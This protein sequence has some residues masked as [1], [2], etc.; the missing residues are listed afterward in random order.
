V[1]LQQ[2]LTAVGGNS[3]LASSAL[4]NSHGFL[5]PL[6]FYEDTEY[7]ERLKHYRV[8]MKS[9]LAVGHYQNTELYS[10]YESLA[11]RWRKEAHSIDGH[12][13]LCGTVL[14]A[15]DIATSKIRDQ[16][17]ALYRRVPKEQIASAFPASGSNQPGN[18]WIDNEPEPEER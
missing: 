1:L 17:A 11:T 14:G 16:Y 3:F 9:C 10:D 7:E 6:R 5:A 13:W 4:L 18:I 15:M 12:P 2:R 8:P